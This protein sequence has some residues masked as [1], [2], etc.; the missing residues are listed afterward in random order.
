MQHL[1]CREQGITVRPSYL[2]TSHQLSQIEV[3]MNP[4]MAR[5]GVCSIVT[6]IVGSGWSWQVRKRDEGFRLQ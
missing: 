2:Q 3:G 1:N 5:N 6:C 4:Y